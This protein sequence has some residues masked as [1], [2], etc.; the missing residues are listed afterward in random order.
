MDLCYNENSIKLKKYFKNEDEFVFTME[1]CDDNLEKMLSEKKGFTPE[2]IYK[3]MSQLNNTFKI[4]ARKRIV[5]RDLK[6]ENILIKYIN[7]E[8]GDYIVKLSDYGVSKQ[9]T[10]TKICK[11]YAGT[12]ITMAPEILEGEGE[13]G[14][15]SKCDLWSIGIIIY[16]LFFNDYPY[17]GNTEF[18]LL[19]TIKSSG[20]KVLKKTN[21]KDLDHLIR[22][23]LIRDIKERFSWENYFNHPFFI[24]KEKNTTDEKQPTIQSKIIIKIKVSNNDK[25]KYKKIFF[26][27]NESLK[28]KNEE[29]VIFEELNQE[30]TELYINDIK[31]DFKKYFEPTLEEGEDFT[32][33]LIIKTKITNCNSMFQACLHIKSIDLSLFDSSEVKDMSL[34]FCKCFNLEELNLGNLN[35]KKV[36]NMKQMF[37]KCKSLKK[38]Y[39]PPTFT[40]ENV[41]DMQLMFFDCISL[42]EVNL[43]F[44][45]QKVE[46][47]KALFKN[48]YLLKK[49][50]LSS[51]KTDKVKKMTLMFEGCNS[52]EEIK[53]DSEKF[54]TTCVVCMGHMF[55]NCSSLKKL[56]LNGFNTENV[57]FMSSM[58]SNCEQLLEMDL[59]NFTN[60]SLN[61]FS[62]MFNGC[63]NLK[64]INLSSFDDNIS[65]SKNMFDNCPM[66]EEVKVKNENIM[67][68]FQKEFDKIIFKV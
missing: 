5:H 38:I 46:N 27:E 60:T 47:M 45:T 40:T 3:I 21:N 20:L 30:N 39:F 32:I 10:T 55:N 35:T 33:K 65:T 54:K 63:I 13:K 17:K 6:L 31:K 15:D 67:K 53:M 49:L 34:M 18:A 37:K 12:A 41:E 24:S 16:R 19:K 58:F 50:D 56:N 23:L 9:V 44:D 7:K 29:K 61:D 11:T 4:M 59:S 43:N 57:K 8:K 36:T 2:E 68:N 22:G 25:K 66:L 42:E 48:C 64:K 62:K 28:K 51:F 26:L 14:Y 1:L 52:L